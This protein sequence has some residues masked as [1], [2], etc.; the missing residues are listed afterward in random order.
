MPKNK[1]KEDEFFIKKRQLNALFD[2]TYPLDINL[3]RGQKPDERGNPIFYPIL[4]SFLLSNGNVRDP[5]IETYDVNGELWVKCTSG[6]ISLFDVLGVPNKKWDYYRL[7]A[8]AKIPDGLVITRDKLN[9][10][11]QSTHYSIRPHWDMPLKKFLM[12][13]DELATQLI[14]EN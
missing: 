11:H 13:L 8:N 5:D 6:G 4:K 14:K 9:P 1:E 10:R 2:S 12:L 3:W 7:P